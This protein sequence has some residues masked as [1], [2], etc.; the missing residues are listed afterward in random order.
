[1]GAMAGMGA[2]GKAFSLVLVLVAVA[3]RS[4]QGTQVQLDGNAIRY[5]GSITEAAN[6]RARELYDSRDVKPTRLSIRS[7]GGDV[8]QGMALG[9]WVFERGLDVEVK[10]G[11]FSSCANYVLT[12]GR[13]IQIGKDAILGWHGGATQG[14]SL[15][16]A[17][18]VE[19]EP[20]GGKKEA[21]VPSE[22]EFEAWV[23]ELVAEET[24]FFERIG[25]DQRITTLGQKAPYPERFPAEKGYIGWD[26]SLEDL[27]R[28]G[29]RHVEVT[30]GGSWSPRALTDERKVFRV[31]LG[32][33][34]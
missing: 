23:R 1:M 33:L 13:R 22:Q 9:K 20:E 32:P 6:R 14:L 12:A 24:Q 28:L 31:E 21:S 3:C 26:Y 5:D 8:I 25:V 27:A 19:G 17:E 15:D 11:C 34:P 4:E 7:G 29:V 18:F 16:H 30:G 10:E 2:M